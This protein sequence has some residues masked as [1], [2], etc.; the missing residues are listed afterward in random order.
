MRTFGLL[1]LLAGFVS[2][3]EP[4][5][6]K[7]ALLVGVN[8]Y[9]HDAMN[10]PE[11]LKYAQADVEEFAKL[12]KAAGYE[13]DLLVG[14]NASKKAIDGKIAALKTQ[15]NSDGVVIVGLAGHGMQLEKDDD[16]YFCPHDCSV[17]DAMREGKPVIVKGQTV[18]EPDPGT[19]VK[20]ADILEQFR[21]G[22]AGTKV[23][24]ADCCRNDPAAGR[25]RAVG[26]DLKID[27]IPNTAVLLSCSQAQ[28]AYEDDSIK[29][30]AFFYHVLKGLEGGK[31]SVAQLN[32]YLEDEVPQQAKKFNGAPNQTPNFIINGRKVLDLQVKVAIGDGVVIEEFEWKGEKRKRR[33]RTLILGGEKVEFVE[34]PAGSFQMG[35]PESDKDA[36]ADEQPQ[37]KVTFTKPLWVAKYPV[38]QGQFEAFSKAAKFTTE[39]ERDDK[40]GWGF[41]GSKYAQSKDYTW[42]NTGWAQTDMHPVVNVTWNDAEAYCKWAAK[43]SRLPIR[44]LDESEYEYASRAGTSTKYFTGDDA[45]SLAGYANVADRSAKAKFSG[46]TIIDIDD[47]EVFTSR[48]GKYKPNGFGLHDMTGNV[49]IWCGDVYDAKLYARG[50]ETNPKSHTDSEQKYRVLRGGSWNSDARFCR[51]ANR[52]RNVPGYRS[53][54]FGFRVCFRLD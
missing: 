13:V 35:S 34:I 20:I 11:A 15:G 31:Q 51:A 43:Q 49:W 22:K 42:K 24:F 17:R 38:T 5:P 41:D 6:K 48:V 9:D 39:P 36:Q 26:T 50:N 21:L 25:G 29:H 44:L 40:G 32:A 7:Y 45:E 23:L 3:E 27:Q 12:L 46:W 16:A 14:S 37:H 52:N 53:S 28:K 54:Y 19:C 47:G 33:V 18:L 2:A 8:K 30:G 4:K 10:R 1:M